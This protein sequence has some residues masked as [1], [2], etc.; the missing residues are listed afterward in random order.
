MPHNVK[1]DIAVGVGIVVASGIGYLIIHKAI[2]K[3]KIQNANK[4]FSKAT[5]PLPSPGA[6]KGYTGSLSI[7]TIQTAQQLAIGLGY[8]YPSWDPRN[9]G[10]NTSM[11]LKTLSTIPKAIMPA[12]EKE[13]TKQYSR[14]LQLDCQ[15][16]LG[17]NYSKVEQLFS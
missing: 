3:Q 17:S 16:L 8:A 9:W 15:K 1:T 6:G 5:I 11:V 14:N 7:N 2:K 13:Y 10:V 4:Q 12:V